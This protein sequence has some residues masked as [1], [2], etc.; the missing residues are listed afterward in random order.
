[1]SVGRAVV[2][3]TLTFLHTNRYPLEQGDFIAWFY[4]ESNILPVNLSSISNKNFKHI[5]SLIL[6]STKNKN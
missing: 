5:I 1:M 3:S 6:A 2:K 4:P